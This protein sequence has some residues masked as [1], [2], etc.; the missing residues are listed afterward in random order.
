MNNIVTYV[1]ES[2]N[3]LLHHVTWPTTAELLSSA[4]LVLL[5]TVILAIIIL[6]LDF[7]F[8]GLILNGFL[9]NIAK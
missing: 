4:K 9:Y 8:S 3:E 7:L 2:Y 5:A 6:L 1:K